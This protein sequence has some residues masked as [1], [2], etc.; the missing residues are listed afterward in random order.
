MPSVFLETSELFPKQNR[1][2]DMLLAVGE[3]EETRRA[4]SM[5]ASKWREHGTSVDPDL[6]DD[7]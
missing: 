3:K 1:T 6:C 5:L 2:S 4:L 7:F